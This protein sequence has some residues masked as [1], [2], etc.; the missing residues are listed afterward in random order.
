MFTKF[1]FPSTGGVH[2]LFLALRRKVLG[3]IRSQRKFVF[4]EIIIVELVN[5]LC[6]NQKK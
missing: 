4:I 3:Y 5:F 2:K 1:N 6:E